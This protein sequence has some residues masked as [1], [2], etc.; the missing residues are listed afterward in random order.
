MEI[1]D[2]TAQHWFKISYNIVFLQLSLTLKICDNLENVITKML[3][4]LELMKVGECS[5][6]S[7]NTWNII[8]Q[9]EL[10]FRI[11]E[12]ICKPWY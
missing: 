12:I 9:F 3:L 8:D 7:F 4:F 5:H 2:I 1:A 11:K 6:C 10:S